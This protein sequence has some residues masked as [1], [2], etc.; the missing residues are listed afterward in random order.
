VFVFGAP[1]SE[2]A[3]WINAEDPGGMQQVA[4]LVRSTFDSEG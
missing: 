2:W 4:D 1:D 3:F